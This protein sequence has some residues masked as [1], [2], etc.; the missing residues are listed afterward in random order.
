MVKDIKHRASERAEVAVELDELGQRTHV[1]ET[2]GK[3]VAAEL[4]SFQLRHQVHFFGDGAGKVVAVD[5]EILPNKRNYR[6]SPDKL[7]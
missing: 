2:A 6:E 5:F 7:E 3:R 4:E 1:G